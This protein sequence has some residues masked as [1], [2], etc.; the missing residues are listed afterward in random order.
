LQF[1]C[2][3]GAARRLNNQLQLQSFKSKTFALLFFA[4]AFDANYCSCNL[5]SMKRA[6]QNK[7]RSEENKFKKPNAH[8]DFCSHFIC[9]N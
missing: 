7:A 9:P 2:S 6:A 1:V 3:R 5:I 8:V 4:A